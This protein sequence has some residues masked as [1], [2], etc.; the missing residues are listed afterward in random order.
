ME[1]FEGKLPQLTEQLTAVAKARLSAGALKFM[2]DSGAKSPDQQKALGKNEMTGPGSLR[3]VTGR[4]ARSLTGTK[5]NITESTF[6]GGLFKI[7]F[8]SEVEYAAVHEYGFTGSVSIPAHQRTITQAFGRPI[9]PKQVDV[10]A[11]SKSM[12]IP[13]RPYLVPALEDQEDF[14]S[15]EITRRVYNLILSL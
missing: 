7:V 5:E 2:R 9:A 11:H 15:R 8:G 3:R 13:K 6:I 10:K 14:I 4:L 1:Q 12:R